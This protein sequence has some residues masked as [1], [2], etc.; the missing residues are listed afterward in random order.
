MYKFLVIYFALF[1]FY[2]TFIFCA[3]Q[4]AILTSCFRL[5]LR[6]ENFVLIYAYSYFY[7]LVITAPVLYHSAV[8][9][10]AYM[11]VSHVFV[12]VD[13]GLWSGSSNRWWDDRLR[14]YSLVSCSR[15]HAQLDALQPD[16]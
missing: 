14:G 9:V 15:D 1:S 16:W 6:T 5:E 8:Y 7:H 10:I 11:H 4:T 3:L 13:S 2:V 12:A